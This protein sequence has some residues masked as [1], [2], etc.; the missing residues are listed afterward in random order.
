MSKKTIEKN[1]RRSLLKEG[2]FAKALFEYELEEHIEEYLQSKQADGDEYFFAVTEHTNDVAMLF[3]DE[4]NR[5]YI[6]E[7]ARA[8]LQKHWRDAYE[9]NLQLLIPQMAEE[10]DAGRLFTAGVKTTTNG[11]STK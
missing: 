3:I 10:L 5:V 9:K 6:N 1:L 7:D 8:K 2:I 4:S 11:R